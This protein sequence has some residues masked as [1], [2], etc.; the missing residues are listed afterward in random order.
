M[1]ANNTDIDASRMTEWKSFLEE[2]RAFVE[3]FDFLKDLAI[4]NPGESS[5]LKI[6]FEK[7]ILQK[8]ATDFLP[9]FGTDIGFCSLLKPQLTFNTD[10]DH[11]P[12]MTKMFG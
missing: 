8:T 1:N 2:H 12:Y 10:L 11:L 6:S 7:R 9:F 5:I 4:D 3:P